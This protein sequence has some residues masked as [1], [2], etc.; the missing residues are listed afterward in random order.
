MEK[1]GRNIVSD[2]GAR[3]RGK[4]IITNDQEASGGEDEMKDKKGEY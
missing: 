4:T 3:K 2:G 1:G